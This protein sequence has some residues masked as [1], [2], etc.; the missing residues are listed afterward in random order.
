MTGFVSMPWVRSTEPA[1]VQR[2]ITNGRLLV[3]HDTSSRIRNNRAMS[4]HEERP[5][6]KGSEPTR[7]HSS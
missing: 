4:D 5:A 3:R 1:H 7:A 6:E 2:S